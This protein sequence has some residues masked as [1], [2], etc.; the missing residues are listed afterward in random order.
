MH[1]FYGEDEYFLVVSGNADLVVEGEGTYPIGPGDLVLIQKN[2]KLDWN[3]HTRLKKYY[4]TV[5]MVG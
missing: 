4:H 1:S 2:T 5:T 3:I